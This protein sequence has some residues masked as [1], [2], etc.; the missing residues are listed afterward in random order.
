MFR[1]AL[2]L[3]CKAKKKELRSLSPEN[4]GPEAILFEIVYSTVQ[5][6]ACSGREMAFLLLAR[7]YAI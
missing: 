4:Q 2:V 1:D 7:S 5:Y 6:T 3:G